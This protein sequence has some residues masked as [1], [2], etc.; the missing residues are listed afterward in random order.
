MQTIR[1]HQKC[2]ARETH[3]MK[4]LL[5]VV[6]GLTLFLSVTILA[7]SQRTAQAQQENNTTMML[8]DLS[9]SMG[10]IEPDGRT[11][12]AVAQQAMIQAIGGVEPG[13]QDIGIRSFS[14]CG[15]TQLEAAPAPV[16]QAA[17]AATINSF[18]PDAQTDIAAALNAV[19][20]DFAGTSG[21]P[22][23]I[24]LSDGAHNCAGDPCMTAANL[25]AA[26]I[27]I[28]VHAIGIGTADTAAEAELAC[29]ASVTGGTVVSVAGA[30]ELLDAIATVITG[31]PTSAIVT[32]V[33]A[34]CIN[35]PIV[36]NDG[37]LGAL[38]V[39]S[40]FTDSASVGRVLVTGQDC[41]FACNMGFDM[42]CDGINGDFCPSEF[43]RNTVAGAGKC[44][45]A[46]YGDQD[47]GD[48]PAS[49]EVT[50][51]DPG[52]ALNAAQVKACEHYARAQ[53]YQARA[54]AAH[55]TG[56]AFLNDFS[57]TLADDQLAKAEAYLAGA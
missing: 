2:T 18:T 36:Q 10:E 1:N 53:V 20:G 23:V 5:A 7:G 51:A 6:L 32:T 42:N 26:G 41:D 49:L 57:Q 43:D 19:A 22:S 47:A 21:R 13:S 29:I 55:A 33:L 35:S 4:T 45:E 37:S 44:I 15:V 56:D 46:L 14:D 17:L 30:D 9:G 39:G 25:I 38:R 11:R 16:D 28:V 48:D 31:D 27:D 3:P 12:L 34:T 54:D 40:T 50:C 8:F 52:A 24:L